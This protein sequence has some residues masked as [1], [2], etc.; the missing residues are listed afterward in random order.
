MDI[1][2]LLLIVFLTIFFAMIWWL[3]L[4]EVTFPVCGNVKEDLI[5]YGLNEEIS[6]ISHSDREWY[7]YNKRLC[8]GYGECDSLNTFCPEVGQEALA[9]KIAL[10]N[11]EHP[12][13][14][15]IY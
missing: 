15:L 12:E 10:E 5:K 6:N 2:L 3:T 4:G 11:G 1:Y 7:Y 14:P 9:I 8:V 13:C